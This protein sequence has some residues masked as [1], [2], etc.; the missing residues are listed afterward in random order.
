MKRLGKITGLGL[1]T[2]GCMM[3]NSVFADE[4]SAPITKTDEIIVTATR[5]PKP[6]KDVPGAVS[7]INQDNIRSKNTLDLA[8]ALEDVTGLKILRYGALGSISSVHIRGLY[9]QHIL[10]MVDGR[11]VNSPSMGS[12]DF[13]S[14]SVDNVKQVEV[15]RGPFS[16][17]YG[18]NAVGG[19]VN[20]ITK[21]VPKEPVKN[22][23][24]LYGSYQTSISTIESGMSDKQGGYLFNSNYKT[25]Q[26]H[27]DNSEH[28]STNTTL[29]LNYQDESSINFTV[30][31]GYFTG[32][33]RFPGAQP[34]SYPA[35]RTASQLAIGNDEVS[36]LVDFGQNEQ[37]YLNT[38]FTSGDLKLHLSLNKKDDINH[39]EWM[40][41]GKRISQDSNYQTTASALEALQSFSFSDNQLIIGANIETNQFDTL[42]KNLDVASSTVT[43]QKWDAE[44]TTYSG[45]IQDEMKF[46]EVILTLGGRFDNPSDFDS[47]F[48]ARGNILYQ[49][50]PSMTIRGSY[51]TSYRAPSLN[52]LYWPVDDFAEGNPNLTPEKGKSAEIGLDYTV[53]SLGDNKEI[54]TGINLFSQDIDQMIAWAPRGSIGPWGNRWTPSN[55]NQAKINGIEFQNH[56]NLIKDVS[57]GLNY[58]LLD[59]TQQN[60]ELT[61]ASLNTMETRTRRLAYA[62]ARKMDLSTEI[63]DVFSIEKF[64]VNMGVQY[65]SETSQYYSDYSAWP[66]VTTMEKSL[67]G[68]WLVNLKTRYSIKD[69]ELFLGLDNLTDKKYAIQFGSSI[70]DRDYPMP[71]RTITTGVTMR[72]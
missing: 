34:S 7:V 20:I 11:I 69:A 71:G 16:A 44:R 15:I 8:D 5:T 33:T 48:S 53:L 68:Y 46:S 54:T 72:F 1:V 51:G 12:A 17:L 52:D 37:T 50:A 38:L 56:F 29:R 13:S 9:S 18:A 21:P 63:K 14:L 32:E 25:S 19:V 10:V 65:I 66:S 64:L 4:P 36:S 42:S 70:D 31:A 47:R 27:R 59:A 23:S 24:T 61:D 41:S 58:T 67:S 40:S 35:E 26:G 62:P 28:Y 30:D 2:I 45:F 55:L 3:A 57:F 49:V 6:L 60:Q 22:I 43:T 39:R